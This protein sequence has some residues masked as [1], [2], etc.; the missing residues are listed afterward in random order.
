[1]L[2]AYCFAVHAN[3]FQAHAGAVKILRLEVDGR[4][5][6][7]DFKILLYDN[8]KEIEP[9]RDGNS[10]IVPSELQGR[11]N[12]GVRIIWGEYDLTFDSVNISKFDTDW[13]VGV[14]K[15]LF[16]EEGTASEISAPLGK[17]LLMVYY[18]SFVPRDGGDGT[19]MTVRVYGQ[20]VTSIPQLF[21]RYREP[22]TDLRERSWRRA[23]RAT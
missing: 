5:V 22:N 10:F 13:V 1:M 14:N 7:K 20:S 15:K 3:P 4:E 16:D 23:G 17:K 11:E 18:I 2:T 8:E 6:H 12:I 21:E 9:V 19:R